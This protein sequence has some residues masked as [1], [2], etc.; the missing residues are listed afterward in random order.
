MNRREFLGYCVPAG[1]TIDLGSLVSW[2]RYSFALSPEDKAQLRGLLIADTHARL[3]GGR[4]YNR[5]ATT[6]EMMKQVGN[7]LGH[8]GVTSWIFSLFSA[9]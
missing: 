5:A 3:H 6:V 8:T 9:H 4:N 1:M 7:S 2:S